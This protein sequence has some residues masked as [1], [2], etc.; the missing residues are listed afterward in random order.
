MSLNLALA[1]IK[2]ADWDFILKNGKRSSTIK[3]YDF[4]NLYYSSFGFVKETLP[5]YIQSADFDGLIRAALNDRGIV[6]FECDTDHLDVNEMLYFVLW[7]MDET[8]VIYELETQQLKSMP[9]P[10]KI[11]AG[12]D[13]L[14]IFGDKNTIDQL[15]GGDILKWN[16]IKKLPYEQV[17]EKQLMLIKTSAFEKKYTKILSEKSKQK[18]GRS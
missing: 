16:D 15:A 18:H 1:T 3:G 11:A 5:D 17:F 2:Q 7:L 9:D 12:I 8:K 6:T 14:N 10:D 4:K 13:E